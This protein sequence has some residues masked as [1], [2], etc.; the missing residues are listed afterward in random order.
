ML[1][2]QSFSQQALAET[3]IKR[4]DSVRVC[5]L[6]Q[7]R[8]R[9]SWSLLQV[10]L[11]ASSDLRAA[12]S[13]WITAP[14]VKRHIKI[15]LPLL[16]WIIVFT[17]LICQSHRPECCCPKYDVIKSHKSAVKNFWVVNAMH[18]KVLFFFSQTQF[19]KHVICRKWNHFNS[20]VCLSKWTKIERKTFLE[21][22]IWLEWPVTLALTY[23]GNCISFSPQLLS[24]FFIIK[25]NLV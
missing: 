23:A 17:M 6:R 18:K 9:G 1:G 13:C 24:M 11:N 25:D 21:L 12:K 15:R 16:W 5:R 3:L 10:I 14:R 19:F 2:L 8:T 22:K 20:S 4:L 7:V